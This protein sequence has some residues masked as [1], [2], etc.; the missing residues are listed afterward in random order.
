MIISSLLLSGAG[1]L[2]LFFSDQS[3]FNRQLISVV[4]GIVLFFVFR[5]I[6]ARMLQRVWWI[7]Y[8]LV[9]V[10]LALVFLGPEVRGAQRWIELFGERIQPSELMKPL[11]VVSL[12]GYVSMRKK[13]GLKQFILFV[14][15]FIAPFLLVFEEPDL[16]NAVVYL[17]T[18]LSLLFISQFQLR[19]YI[20]PIL[21]LLVGIPFTWPHLENYQKLRI[22]TFINPTYDI[23]GAGYNAYQ[24]L[25]AVGSGG[26]LGKGLGQG[27]QSKL[28]FLPEY[29][30]DFV[31]AAG[32][33][34]VGFIGGLVLLVLYAYFL[35]SILNNGI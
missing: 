24:A 5:R 10:M 20:L 17:F 30:T 2:L 22:L 26:W 12:A 9:I 18:F 34:Q 13:F 14:L 7:W 31:F 6:D 21:I 1:L 28:A 19:Y 25:I 33:E 11:F 29:H 27:T 16:G 4:I 8:A 23:Q 32:I 15:F 3:L 35:F